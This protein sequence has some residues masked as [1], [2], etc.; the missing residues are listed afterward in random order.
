MVLVQ[1][2]ESN[3]E[4]VIYYLSHN[5]TKTKSKYA[6]VEKLALV[7]VQIV[8]R[9]CHYIL[10]RK[11]TLIYDCNPMVYILTRKLLGGEVFQ[12]ECHPTG[13]RFGIH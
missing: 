1:E 2:D 6:H 9:F 7:V 13:I 8:Q 4:H 3:E 10:L 11:N 5:L 12:M